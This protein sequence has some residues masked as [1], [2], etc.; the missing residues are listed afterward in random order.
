YHEEWYNVLLGCKERARVLLA[1]LIAYVLFPVQVRQKQLFFDPLAAPIIDEQ[2]LLRRRLLIVKSLT[3]ELNNNK[4]YLESLLEVNLDYQYAMKIALHEL[5]LCPQY[6]EIWDE[7]S[8]D[9]ERMIKF[10]RAC[11]LESP[12]AN[13]TRD[14]VRSLTTDE[15][16]LLHTYK[17]KRTKFVESLKKESLRLSEKDNSLIK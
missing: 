7:Y 10:L 9:L 1:Q 13:L 14:E 2:G 15:V 16:I 11:Q 5:A 4:T 17:E 8:E 6:Y 12:L 3:A